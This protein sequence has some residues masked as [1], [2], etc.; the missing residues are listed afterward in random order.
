[1][2]APAGG[3]A[4][5]LGL[6]WCTVPLKSVRRCAANI[7]T[8]GVEKTQGPSDLNDAY[9]AESCR[10]KDRQTNFNLQSLATLKLVDRD[11]DPPLQPAKSSRRT[12]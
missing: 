5:V 8:S 12:I 9:A 4:S 10:Y 2:I 7:K 1:M 3:C 11:T 6:V